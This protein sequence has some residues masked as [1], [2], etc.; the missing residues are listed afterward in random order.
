MNLDNYLQANH[1]QLLKLEELVD[2]IL[3]IVDCRINAGLR[4]I[5]DLMLCEV[6]GENEQWTIESFVERT[7][8]RC[9]SI[10][11]MIN[12]RQNLIEIAVRDLITEVSK[13][14]PEAQRREM[15]PAYETVYGYYNSQSFEALVQNTKASLDILKARLGSSG[16]TQYG[17]NPHKPFF[18]T[19]L[20]LS[21]PNI[22]LQP[23]LE[24]IQ[25]SLN[26]V[27]GLILD[28]SKKVNNWKPLISVEDDPT[29]VSRL[30][31]TSQVAA[32]KDVTKVAV[33]LSSTIN[34]MKKDIE[35]HREQFIKYD[36]V[37]KDDKNEVIK[38]FLAANPTITDFESE[39]NRFEYV[40]REILEIPNQTQI[41]LLL[42]SAEPLKLALTTETKQ[43]KQAYGLNLNLMVK[44]AME[45]MIEY[46]ENKT[47]RL[48]RKV[49]D[50]DDLRMA[51]QTLSEI[52]ESE[53]NIDLKLQPIEEAYLL[54]T[55]HNVS[56]TKEETE[57]VDSLRYSW[58]KLKQLVTDVQANLSKVQPVFKAE[59]I[60]SVQKFT[61]DVTEFSDDYVKNGP[62]VSN[63]PPKVASE[64]LNVFQRTFDELNR[65]WETYSAGEELFSLPVTQFPTLVK[66]KKELKLLQNLYALYN[67]VLERRSVYYE[68]YWADANFEKMNAEMADFQNKIKKLPKAMKDWDSFNELRKVV[69]D[70]TA[71][72]PLLEMMSNKAIQVLFL[73]GECI[74]LTV[75]APSL[76]SHHATHQDPIQ[77]G[78]RPLF[79]EKLDGGSPP[80]SPRRY[81]RNL[82]RC[83]EGSR[84]RGEVEGRGYRM[85]REGVHL[86]SLQ[87]PWQSH[88]EAFSHLGNHCFHGRFPDDPWFPHE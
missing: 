42:V 24:D 68:M 33:M 56:V 44:T 40:E 16:S 49:A 15:R 75:L 5:A 53:V 64:R 82:Y 13:A 70:M 2:K 87:D 59:L 57:M 22:V 6:P 63:I 67:D 3:D 61:L 80:S 9:T 10:I 60:S 26:R 54:L 20:V 65:K 4:K 55:K 11:Q 43:W 73:N 28:V 74:N 88:I 30:E 77:L 50:I 62:M 19:E 27:T 18:R 29:A 45:Q 71:M 47:M 86:C 36:F 41:T 66:I 76:G 51:V 35:T 34:S 48:S 38:N 1:Q 8:A 52:R 72:V 32:N 84:Y 7:E 25:L 37:W 21:I 14:V 78:S 23:R 83:R 17:K 85:G 31:D 39:I 46:M 58:K 12:T 79:P 81:R 69:D